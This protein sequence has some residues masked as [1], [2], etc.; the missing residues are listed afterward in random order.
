[1]LLAALAAVLPLGACQQEGQSLPP[2]GARI[3]Q[4]SVSGLSSGAYMAGQF[5]VAHSRIVVGAAII[6]GGPYGCA[7]S[8]YADVMPGPGTAIL[9]LSKAVN[10]CMLNGLQ[11]LG[12]PNSHQLGDRARRLAAQG[13]VDPLENLT[14]DHIYLFAG[15]ED[16]TV[17]PAIVAAAAAFYLELGVPPPKIKHVTDVPAGHG[18]V[19][20]D[21]GLG[22]GV[23]G[24]PYIVDCDYDQAGD[25]LRH[26]YGELAPKSA[27]ATGQLLVFD[28]SEFTHDLGG[29]GMSTLGAAYVPAD[30]GNGGGCRVHIVFHGCGQY[31]SAVGDAFTTDTGFGPWADTNRLI[32]LFPQAAPSPSNPQGCWDWWGYTGRDF[33]TKRAPQIIAVRRMLERLA[34]KRAMS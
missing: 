3:D 34:G 17:V 24:A 9:N 8:L 20:E 18:F 25:L 15:T 10:G 14:D 28:Q 19:T 23:S 7:E 2:L 13:R 31:R 26:I 12:V 29:H 4:T 27:A 16:R 11:L 6:A 33:L 32:V 22:C 21:K 30:C 5:Q 1:L